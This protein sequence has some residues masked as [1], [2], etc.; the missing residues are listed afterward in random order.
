MVV[1]CRISSRNF[2]SVTAGHGSASPW[3]NSQF[4]GGG[5][6]GGV[7]T[8]GVCLG[9]AQIRILAVTWARG[10]EP[11]FRRHLSRVQP[12]T[13]YGFHASEGTKRAP[14]HPYRPP[15]GGGGGGGVHTGGLGLHMARIRILAVTWV[16]GLEPQ[17]PWHLPG[18]QPPTLYGFHTSE[19]TKRAP[20]H[21]YRLPWWGGGGGGPH[22]GVGP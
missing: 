14:R 17:F 19:G 11:Q 10:P 6:G 15:L 2:R 4:T 16:R 13:L 7:H 3:R 22:W 18:V 12:P 5:G 9:I 8:G 21:P 20:R 1:G